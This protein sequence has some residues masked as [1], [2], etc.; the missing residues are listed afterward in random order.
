[1]KKFLLIIT[2]VLMVLSGCEKAPSEIIKEPS[3][4]E[5]SVSEESKPEIVEPEEDFEHN[6]VSETIGIEDV[7]YSEKRGY[8]GIYVVFGKNK[9]DVP[10]DLDEPG[11]PPFGWYGSKKITV[12]VYRKDYDSS[13][14]N[15][16]STDN[17]GEL[18]HEYTFGIEPGEIQQI[19]VHF[20]DEEN[21]FFSVNY[22]DGTGLLYRVHNRGA[23]IEKV[24]EVGNVWNMVFV[25]EKDRKSVV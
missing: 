25:D 20:Y 8:T 13:L 6:P 24:G 2:V 3:S 7:A 10:F 5:S 19:I 1:M 16:L 4:S 11:I 23:L 21:G 22:A 9:A 15:V 12:F 18:W 17:Q 14:V